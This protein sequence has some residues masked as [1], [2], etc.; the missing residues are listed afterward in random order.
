MSKITLLKRNVFLCILRRA[1][2]LPKTYILRR[3]QQLP[4]VAYI[5]VKGKCVVMRMITRK[6]LNECGFMHGIVWA[7][8]L[9]N[10]SQCVRSSFAIES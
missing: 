8:S 7:R 4:G 6:Y 9:H 10:I 2:Q 3:K 1:G 5:I